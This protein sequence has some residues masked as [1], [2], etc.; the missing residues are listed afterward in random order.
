MLGSR[1]HP[2]PEQTRGP[3]NAQELPDPV[4]EPLDR[5]YLDGVAIGPRSSK[6]SRTPPGGQMASSEP[7][8]IASSTAGPWAPRTFRVG[9]D[10]DTALDRR[11]GG[12]KVGAEADPST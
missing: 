4:R 2:E 10:C 6:S 8:A 1:V 11:D 12:N 9:Q 5:E 7:A 3:A